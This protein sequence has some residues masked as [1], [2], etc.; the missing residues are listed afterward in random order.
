MLAYEVENITNLAITIEDCG[1]LLSGF[2]SKARIPEEQ[3]LKS[4]S[5]LGIQS[6][7]KWKKIT[8]PD[9]WPFAKSVP[10]PAI[11]HN[12]IPQERSAP[13]SSANDNRISILLDRMDRLIQVMERSGGSSLSVEKEHVSSSYHALDE[14]LFIASNLIPKDAESRL[15]VRT[16][17]SESDSLDEAAKALRAIRK[18]RK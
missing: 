17:S 11:V 12:V 15:E 10:N 8:I 1:I 7:I 3:F 13:A 4:K 5:L 18:G 6:M 2:G 16:S 9:I 14:P